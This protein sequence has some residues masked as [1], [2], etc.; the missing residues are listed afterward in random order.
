MW[1]YFQSKNL[2]EAQAIFQ[3]IEKNEMQ[4]SSFAYR[5]R[6]RLVRLDMLSKIKK[7]EPEEEEEEEDDEEEEEMMPEDL[8]TYDD[9]DYEE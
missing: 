3:E 6:S 2:K 4:P 5:I 1:M 7:P 8:D 9:E